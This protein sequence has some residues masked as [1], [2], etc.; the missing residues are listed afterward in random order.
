MGDVYVRQIV[1][2]YEKMIGTLK[3]EHNLERGPYQ[4]QRE[5]ASEVADHF[6]E[7]PGQSD[8]QS[9]VEMI[10]EAFYRVR[11]GERPLNN[12]SAE[13]VERMAKELDAQLKIKLPPKSDPVH[14]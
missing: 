4:T 14:A 13:Q 8:I 1:P 10:T 2:F 7:H 9:A 6:T 12:H 3:R 11:F 5:F